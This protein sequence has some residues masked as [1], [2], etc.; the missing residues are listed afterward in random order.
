MPALMLRDRSVTLAVVGLDMDGVQRDTAYRAY[1]SLC[2][3]VVEL[4]GIPPGYAAWARR[5]SHDFLPFYRACGVSATAGVITE[6]YRRH[7]AHLEEDAVPFSDVAGFLSHLEASDL[8]AF[9]VSNASL[10]YLQEWLA[11]HDLNAK[12]AH[13]GSASGDKQ[14]SL[15][16]ACEA[17]GVPAAAACYVG[18]LGCDMRNAADAGLLPIGITRG[19]ET[20]EALIA[21]GALFVVDTL[22][23]LA[24]Y[25]AP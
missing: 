13:V 19:Y 1:Q 20:R 24:A 21:S 7:Q 25:I 18:D 23:E 11:V 8:K 2:K 15:E 3:T 5:F 14:A 22:E 4:G 6:V 12:F 16:K 9:V 17:L 10:E